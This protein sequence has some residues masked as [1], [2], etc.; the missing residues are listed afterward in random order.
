MSQKIHIN[1][2]FLQ[3]FYYPERKD[4]DFIVKQIL[5]TTNSHWA[6]QQ[7]VYNE[8]EEQIINILDNNVKE[9]LI[10]FQI[11]DVIKYIINNL[12]SMYRR[13]EN[14]DKDLKI[15]FLK[16]FFQNIKIDI[17]KKLVKTIIFKNKY[18]EEIVNTLSSIYDIISNTMV[19]C[20]D[21]TVFDPLIKEFNNY[22]IKYIS[23]TDILQSYKI[24]QNNNN[25]LKKLFNYNLPCISIIIDNIIGYIKNNGT[26]YIDQWKQ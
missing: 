26:T 10:N 16:S 19:D 22:T 25:I 3:I 11:S 7:Y 21:C 23:N 17:L 9:L 2:D 24:Y 13:F 15:M 18:Y 8:P 1:N 5:Y 4:F 20:K 6:I 12:I 14:I